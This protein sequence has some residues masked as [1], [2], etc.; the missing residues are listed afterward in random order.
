MTL[1]YFTMTQ[2]C[3]TSVR[4]LHLIHRH[5]GVSTA[6]IYLIVTQEYPQP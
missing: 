4:D 5:A 3:P 6:S 2:E 1:L